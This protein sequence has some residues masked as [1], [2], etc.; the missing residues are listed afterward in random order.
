MPAGP[1][2]VSG[3][4][5]LPPRALP[6]ALGRDHHRQRVAEPLA[7]ALPGPHRREA[8]ALRARRR[9]AR[10]PA[11]R[12]STRR[13][14]AGIERHREYA[15]TWFAFAATALGLWIALNL[16]AR[17]DETHAAREAPPHRC[18][19]PRARSWPRWS[20]YVF[21]RPEPT[22]QLRRA[23]AA[24]RGDLRRRVPARRRRRIPLRRACAARWV[25]LASDSRECDAACGAKLYAMRQV[26]LA[27]GRDASRVARVVRGAG[28]LRG[29]PG[30]RPTRTCSA[31][32][33][34][35]ALRPRA[36]RTTAP[37]STS[38]TRAAT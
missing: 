31:L 3:I 9:R 29:A 22:A 28:D 1:V 11:C 5:A 17:R 38:W 35:C 14:D 13:P 27:L 7:R 19:L 18:G 24:A 21:F 26:R 8:A 12:R 32:I 16:Q 20:T 15:L 30:P 6:R 36:R 33:A 25:L 4:A 10:R 34:G 37:T 2:E 23:A